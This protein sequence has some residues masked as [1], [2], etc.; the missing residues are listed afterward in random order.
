MRS[1]SCRMIEQ[2]V[3]LTAIWWSTR[4]GKGTAEVH[5][6]FHSQA[7]VKH[8]SRQIE[9]SFEGLPA[10]Y[11][12]NAMLLSHVSRSRRTSKAPSHRCAQAALFEHRPASW[13]SMREFD[14]FSCA[15]PAVQSI[16]HT[17][18]R[19]DEHSIQSAG[20]QRVDVGL[21]ATRPRS[22]AAGE[23]E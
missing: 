5:E 23:Q 16:K 15:R 19:V 14:A 20:G 2:L 1:K 3:Q 12:V 11:D 8:A 22:L 13:S 21:A 6:K 7:I 10:N 17:S 4:K 9:S 18:S